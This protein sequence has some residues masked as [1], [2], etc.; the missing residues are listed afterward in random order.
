MSMHTQKRGGGLYSHRL[1][2]KPETQEKKMNH[3]GLIVLEKLNYYRY[4]V[5]LQLAAGFDSVVFYMRAWGISPVDLPS[6]SF[7]TSRLLQTSSNLRNNRKYSY[8]WF[9]GCI[10]LR[11]MW[12]SGISIPV[13]ILNQPVP[14][15]LSLLTCL[16]PFPTLSCFHSAL[17]PFVS[18]PTPPF[19]P[20]FSFLSLFPSMP[21]LVSMCAWMIDSFGNEEQRHKFC[22][23]LCTMEKF[24]SYC[25]TEPGAFILPASDT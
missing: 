7:G 8:F 23:P 10:N 25:L 5:G 1:I 20:G 15:K 21:F 2:R 3:V 17:S 13:M 24:A 6:P 9:L 19:S 4:T 16:F 12:A 11:N 22:P 14:F 18:F